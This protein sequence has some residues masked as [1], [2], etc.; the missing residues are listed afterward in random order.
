MAC[1]QGQIGFS[2]QPSQIGFSD[3]PD[4]VGFVDCP[5]A[6]EACCDNGWDDDDD[7][8]DGDDD[9]TLTLH[10]TVTVPRSVVEDLVY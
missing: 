3:Q 5:C 1:C 2:D 10:G 4:Q 7:E 9:V 8:D 6:A